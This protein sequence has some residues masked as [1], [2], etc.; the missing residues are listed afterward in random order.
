MNQTSILIVEDEGIVAESLGIK[1]EQLGYEVAGIAANGEEGVE[2]ALAQRPRLILM[3]I[4]LEGPLDGIGAAEAIQAQCDIPVIY[5]TAH[6]D[7]AT[8]ARAKLTGP[9]GYILKPFET[10][11]LATQIELALYKHQADKEVREQREWLRV[12]LSSIGD[13]VIATDAHG[14]ITFLNPVAESLTGWKQEEANGRPVREVFRIINEYSRKEV[15]NPASKVIRNGRIVGLANHT[16]LLRRGGGEVPIDDSGAPITDGQGRIQGVVLV[17]RDITER[18]KA[19]I[20]LRDSE[21]RFRGM[22]ENAPDPIYI[23]TEQKFAYLNPAACRL[24]HITSADELVGT[25]V[26]ERILHDDRHIVEDRRRRIHEGIEPD[27]SMLEHRFLRVDGSSVWV[28]TKGEPIVYQGKNGA[29]VFVRDVSRRRKDR[30]LLLESESR[31]RTLAESAPVG[32]V[33]SD[34]NEKVLYINH[35]FTEL[36]GYTMQEMPSVEQW[37]PLAYPDE[38]QRTDAQTKW[39]AAVEKATR[40][41]APVEPME[42]PVTCKDGTV[43]HIKFQAASSDG[44]N[45]V[46]FSDVTRRKQNEERIKHINQVLIAI[47]SV[48]QL[49][50]YEKDRDTLM[51][52]ACETLVETRGY[53]FAWIALQDAAGKLQLAAESGMGEDFAPIVAEFECG[54]APACYRRA[55]S[56][57]QK[58]TT[59]LSTAVHCGACPLA[60]KHC[61]TGV[62]AGVL[63]HGDHR[64][65]GIMVALPAGMGNDKY[66]QSLFEELVDDL[67]YALH[68]IEQQQQRER[69]EAKFRVLFESSSDGILIADI[70]TKQFKYANPAVCRFLGYSATELESL[71][72]ADIH[73]KDELPIIITNF[74]EQVRGEKE[75]TPDISCLRKDGSVVYADV[76]A[77]P[78]MIDGRA[79]LAG[80]FRDITERKLAEQEQEKLQAQLIQAQKMESV[81]RLAGG[82]AHDYNNIL[83]VIL[84]YTE[85]ALDRDDLPQGLHDDLKAIYSSAIRSRDITRQL[86]AFARKQTIAPEVLDL[87]IT[88]ESMLSILRRLIGEDLDL[89]WLPGRTVWPVLMDPSQIDQILANL[90]VNARDAIADVGKVTIETGT[91]TIDQEYCWDHSGFVPGD[92]VVLSVSD[93]G[94]GMD[95][96]TLGQI[97]EPFYTTKAV[98]KGTGLGLATVYGI[99]KQNNGFI[100]V[101]SEPDEGTT[102][103]VYLPRQAGAIPENILELKGKTAMGRG[104]LLLVVED[105]VSILKLAERILSGLNYKVLTAK[106]P[107]EA[108]SLAEAHNAEID[109][110]I[111]DVVMPEMNG[112]ELAEKLQANLC[113]N[114][115]CLYMSGYTANVIAHRGVL[116]KGGRSHSWG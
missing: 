36:F 78:I 53:R 14:F 6:S 86:L 85:L 25:H 30:E 106:T 75:L 34:R 96:D 63:T 2:M 67:G 97:F 11:D 60:C 12:T 56:S 101:Y 49:I 32:I 65:G 3:D 21:K 92:F 39:A 73:P 105:D 33:I 28:E 19:E 8:L 107:G 54:Q 80:F 102:F 27:R 9:F 76:N 109:L 40:L 57:Q 108:L 24:F 26:I 81:G 1:L 104:E 58:V 44:L 93:N 68:G 48:N 77:V 7:P 22:I 110:L 31:F 94:C 52:R 98:G 88:I 87:N 100:N 66:E 99:V 17:F 79:C 35:R 82:V 10:R 61:G 16:I 46:L 50:T 74:E 42:F 5:L 13:G 112:R 20:T 83:S 114:L 15:E 90:C 115:K 89:A 51:R 116:D 37:W 64:Y 69:A 62:F 95:R 29:L 18:R 43:R 59:L 41:K 84:G 70:E 71:K 23:Q 72:V 55:M 113:P 111:T 45:F 103:R 38:A 91:V 4:Q 47:R